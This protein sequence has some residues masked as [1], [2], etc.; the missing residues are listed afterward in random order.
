MERLDASP[1]APAAL[2]FLSRPRRGRRHEL[3]SE[4]LRRLG[5]PPPITFEVFDDA[6]LRRA[7]ELSFG[8]YQ[9]PTLDLARTRYLLGFGADLLG[10]WNSPLAHSRG[11]RRDA[12]GPRR[13]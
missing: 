1:A 8:R 7:N 10:T 12:P 9:L 3:V 2:A 5:A 13:A 11:L 4:F 6:V